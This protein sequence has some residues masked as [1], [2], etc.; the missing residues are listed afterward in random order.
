MGG[1]SAEREIAVGT[2]QAIARALEQLGHDVV[3]MDLDLG[4]N[5]FRAISEAR[6]DA[7]FL[8]LRGHLSEDGC[9]QGM[10]E[11]LGVPYTG[12]GVLGSALAMDRLKS[13]ELFRMHNLPTTGYYTYEGEGSRDD[14]L[15]HHGSFGFPAVVRARHCGS[16]G[17]RMAVTCAEELVHSVQRTQQLDP[18]VMV[19][20]LMTGTEIS[21]AVL[22]GRAMGCV[23]TGSATG[24]QASQPLRTPAISESLCRGAMQLALRA[25]QVLDVNGAA[26]VN[27]ITSDQQN[28]YVLEVDAAPELTPTSAFSR[29]AAAAG[30]S[31]PQ[32]CGAILQTARVHAPV[33]R[34]TKRAEIVPLAA[35]AEPLRAAVNQ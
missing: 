4:R 10:L 14:V 27:M 20:R 32:L 24:A 2:G 8:A 18:S 9:T 17:A 22:N 5:A 15:E 19:E 35:V 1:T 33:A 11:I 13:K 6:L 26:I 21:V 3:R 23:E 34:Q 25:A 16:K 31:F 7:A 28:E 29:M 12:P 30:L